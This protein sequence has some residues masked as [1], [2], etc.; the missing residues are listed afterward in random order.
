VVS[1][2][3]DAQ[4]EELRRQD[5]E[6]EANRLEYERL[7]GQRRREKRRAERVLIDGLWVHPNAPHGKLHAY[8]NWTC[9]CTPCG[10]AMKDYLAKRRQEA[11][12][13]VPA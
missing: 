10:N 2:R 9:R 1:D 8:T 5:I 13:L 7:T 4:L 11:K 6:R 12:E 3:I